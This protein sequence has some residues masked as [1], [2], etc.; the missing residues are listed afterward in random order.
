MRK[1][2]ASCRAVCCRAR[3]DLGCGRGCV[4]CLLE[5]DCGRYQFPP[6]ASGGLPSARPTGG[7]RPLYRDNAYNLTLEFYEWY[8]LRVRR[9]DRL[10]WAPGSAGQP[11]RGV[12]QVRSSA[13]RASLSPGES[14]GFK[15][16]RTANER[17]DLG[18]VAQLPAESS[19]FAADAGSIP[20]ASTTCQREG[21]AFPSGSR[22]LAR[23]AGSS[24]G[25]AGG[26]PAPGRGR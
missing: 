1:S 23:V 25:G 8:V 7:Y 17:H 18:C 16:P 13:G 14:Q 3:D 24:R 6:S 26:G 15:S 2:V 22:P 11:V 12:W 20:V 4:Q 19:S 9:G 5:R 21:D 10:W